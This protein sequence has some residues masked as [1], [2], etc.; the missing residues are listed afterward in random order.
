[1][2]LREAVLPTPPR[3]HRFRRRIWLVVAAVLAIAVAVPPTTSAVT[4]L[5]GT[6][7]FG[8][9]VFTLE[10]GSTCAPD[11]SGTIVFS[12]TFPVSAPAAGTFSATGTI[13]L[14]TGQD[15]GGF[16]PITAFAGSFTITGTGDPISGPLSLAP[17]RP[18]T[19]FGTADFM[20]RAA[21]ASVGYSAYFQLTARFEATDGAGFSETGFLNL[22]GADAR[23]IS[24]PDFSTVGFWVK[25]TMSIQ[26]DNNTDESSRRIQYSSPPEPTG[27]ETLT[28]LTQPAPIDDV[29][30]RVT[31]SD[32]TATDG[33][34]YDGVDTLVT[35]PG[36]TDP[37]IFGVGQVIV[38]IHQ[39]LLAE[40]T[41][42]FLA[43]I[44]LVSGDALVTGSSTS[45]WIID[46]DEDTLSLPDL[47]VVEG[48]E[49]D[50]TQFDFVVD[51]NRIGNGQGYGCLG[52]VG[53]TAT[54]SLTFEDDAVVGFDC[55]TTTLGYG[56]V[57]P[58]EDGRQFT[59]GY[60]IGDDE[61]EPDETIEL[62]IDYL[63]GARLVDGT[64]TVTI[65]DDD[66]PDLDDDGIDDAIETG[67]PGGF[68][69]GATTSGS[70]DADPA[71]LGVIVHDLPDP[72][73]VHITAGAG[74]G[75]VDLT[76]C[77]YPSQLAAGSDISITC[78]SIHATVDAGVLTVDLGGGDAVRIPAGGAADISTG[79]DGRFAVTSTGDVAVVLVLDGTEVPLEPGA[80]PY[81]ETYAFGGFQSPVDGGTTLNKVKAGAVVPVKFSL[82]GDQG[83][84]IFQAGS[85]SSTGMACGN[86]PVDPLEETGETAGPILTYQRG[87]DRYQYNWKTQKAW[88]GSCRVL[89]LRFADGSSQEARFTFTK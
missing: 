18:V 49:G 75:V 69:D 45:A 48:D 83:L 74:T 19:M 4:T 58:V 65:L 1:M 89:T 79:A 50:V 41:E 17:A 34:D 37:D 57:V 81:A 71:G 3:R 61:I 80:P 2:A 78:G 20:N 33:V 52:V 64:V 44:E 27:G 46:D 11:G 43:E 21:C 68:A 70:V 77:G 28:I 56:A 31:T 82:H 13:T 6:Q 10:P 16:N 29:V 66:D 54:V 24:P 59:A 38:P 47:T 35:I 72:A 7:G 88:A 63:F 55:Q 73:G 39:D 30:V 32:E 85:P 86:A 67:T 9:N 8:T 42:T 62:A 25:P 87:G 23:P 51:S 53:G 15:S 60:I 76:L 84:A 14:G 36:T 5:R 40:G 12:T 26:A 22:A